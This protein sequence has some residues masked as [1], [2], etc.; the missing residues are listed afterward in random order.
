MVF[1]MYE[2]SCV[3]CVC[4]WNSL[5]SYL[6]EENVGESC[7]PAPRTPRAE[8]PQSNR[9]PSPKAT[10]CGDSKFALSAG[11]TSPHAG[12]KRR[13]SEGSSI[14]P[15]KEAKAM[16]DSAAAME[17]E[18]G[19]KEENERI[20]VP[21]KEETKENALE[22]KERAKDSARP[23]GVAA[24]HALAA[25][26]AAVA[27]AAAGSAFVTK[28]AGDGPASG[29]RDG[30]VEENVVDPKTGSGCSQKS[31]GSEGGGVSTRAT[32]SS[33]R[34]SMREA[35]KSPEKKGAVKKER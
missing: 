1:E 13:K 3:F 34:S 31:G 18:A 9:D 25:A 8:Q 4:F 28:S 10:D 5:G 11:A 33:A 32:R 19:N 24:A 23:T 26:T 21:P 12:D 27:A 29:L 35:A 15:R 2:S 17:A 16:K 30:G 22:S 6:Q 7:E 20:E 14:S